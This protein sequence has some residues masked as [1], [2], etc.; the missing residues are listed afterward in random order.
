LHPQRLATGGDDIRLKRD[1]NGVV[2]MGIRQFLSDEGSID[3]RGGAKG[4]ADRRRSGRLDRG[5]ACMGTAY[6]IPASR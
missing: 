2:T 4:R 6:R 5:Q 1:E 3:P